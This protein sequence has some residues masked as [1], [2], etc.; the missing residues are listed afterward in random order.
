[1]SLPSGHQPSWIEMHAVDVGVDVSAG[2]FGNGGGGGVGGNVAPPPPVQGSFSGQQKKKN[3]PQSASENSRKQHPSAM[4]RAPATLYPDKSS[5]KNNSARGGGALPPA[6]ARALNRLSAVSGPSGAE[7]LPALSV[8]NGYRRGPV[9]TY[10]VGNIVSRESTLSVHADL[11]PPASRSNYSTGIQNLPQQPQ[12]YQML[13][14]PPTR[15]WVSR[16]GTLWADDQL[17]EPE[18]EKSAPAFVVHQTGGANKDTLQALAEDI[19]VEDGWGDASPPLRQASAPVVA[20]VREGSEQFLG[21]AAR[22]ALRLSRKSLMSLWDDVIFPSLGPAARLETDRLENSVRQALA[23]GNDDEAH[24]V[25]RHCFHEMY[26]RMPLFR[27]DVLKR[28]EELE[29]SAA[30]LVAVSAEARQAEM[31]A[32]AYKARVRDLE[33]RGA[34]SN[35]GGATGS[36]WGVGVSSDWGRTAVSTLLEAKSIST[37]RKSVAD[38]ESLAAAAAGAPAGA[39]L[40]AEQDG[41][42]FVNEDVQAEYVLD[43]LGLTAMAAE[44]HAAASALRSSDSALENARK[45]MVSCKELLAGVSGDDLATERGDLTRLS[46]DIERATKRVLRLQAGCDRHATALRSAFGASTAQGSLLGVELGGNLDWTDMRRSIY[47]TGNGSRRESGLTEMLL[48]SSTRLLERISQRLASVYGGGGAPAAAPAQSEEQMLNSEL[49]QMNFDLAEVVKHL[50][51]ENEKLKFSLDTEKQYAK[52]LARKFLSSRSA[53]AAADA[54]EPLL[55]DLREVLTKH[56]YAL[57]VE[58]TVTF[59]EPA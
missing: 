51:D 47:T 39:G 8:H 58:K 6:S 29:A 19:A 45:V 7:P 30:A 14:P 22:G 9:A 21:V 48:R 59:D 35:P 32:E 53:A 56:G 13:R 24:R 23:T 52:S 5:S 34:D 36:F 55:A 17:M 15:S 27:R 31:V 49:G 4:T 44:S 38:A 28:F 41:D 43:A 50:Q 12:P 54:N 25:I 1:M 16:G 40:S 3:N 20:E 57:D 26:R 42:G 11:R 33:R 37:R 18:S 2:G 10:V 46:D